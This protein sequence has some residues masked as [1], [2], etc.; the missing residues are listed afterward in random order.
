MIW[1]GL[2]DVL[3]TERS[4]GALAAC[5]VLLLIQRRP[6][7]PP[8][9]GRVL[10]ARQRLRLPGVTTRH[11]GKRIGR[12][13]LGRL[14]EPHPAS[15]AA[16]LI[17]Q[18]AALL[19]SGIPPAVAWQLVADNA[20]H[21]DFGLRLRAGA[22]AVA[23]GLPPAPALTAAAPESGR[24]SRRERGIDP[25]A[26]L[27]AAWSTV[28]ATGAAP[29]ASLESLAHGLRASADAAAGQA[30]ALAAPQATAR[31]LLVL[32]LL[33][34]VLGTLMGADPVRALFG[35]A[36]GRLSLLAGLGFIIVG[37]LWT[38]ALLRAAGG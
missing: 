7:A 28:V 25:A 3:T 23:R 13:S 30:A 12:A 5:F 20:G 19:R 17:E 34:L 29:A 1:A 15:D 2:T 26:G 22:S 35:T 10:P 6:G 38:K 24:A 14:T 32:P 11:Q 4:V 8:T 36:V 31:V 16:A 27:A 18:L 37:L 21:D 9:R 33:G